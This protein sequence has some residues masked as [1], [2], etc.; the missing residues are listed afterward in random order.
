MIKIFE[1]F[2]TLKS[3]DE[4]EGSGMGL[5]LIKKIVE[6]QGGSIQVKSKLNE[7]SEFIF[8]W[9]HFKKKDGAQ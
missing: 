2:Q 8:T 5:A 4:V 6:K 9:S 7:G 1:M 3:R